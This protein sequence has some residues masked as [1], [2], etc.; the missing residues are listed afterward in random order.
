VRIKRGGPL[1]HLK[2]YEV[3]GLVLRTGSANFSASGENDQDNDLVVDRDPAD[4]ARFEAK[5]EK[6]WSAAA[7]MIEFAPAIKALEPRG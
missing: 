3:D 2:S 4:A 1:Q 7:P 6:M 5:S